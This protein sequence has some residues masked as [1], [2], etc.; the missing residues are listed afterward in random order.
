MGRFVEKILVLY[1]FE[2][3]GQTGGRPGHI[4]CTGV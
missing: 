4:I 1:Y 3:N 2:A